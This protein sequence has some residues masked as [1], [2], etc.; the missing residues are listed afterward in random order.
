MKV[1]E[2]KKVKGLMLFWCPGCKGLH[3][4]PTQNSHANN[5]RFNGDLNEPT[6][7]PSIL[8]KIAPNGEWQT[9]CHSY[10]TDGQISFLS[11]SPHSLSCQ[12]VELED[13]D[14]ESSFYYSWEQGD[15]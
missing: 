3:Q 14:T 15:Y 12:T 8:T 6:F 2:S 9:Q 5:W 1:I 13:I 4:V 10:V 11:D 7:T